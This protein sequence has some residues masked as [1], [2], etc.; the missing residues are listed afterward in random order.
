MR[1]NAANTRRRT[2]ARL[3]L[4][5]FV[6]AV[7]TLGVS[8]AVPA[9]PADAQ[10]GVSAFGHAASAA[11]Q[12]AAASRTPPRKGEFNLPVAIVMWSLMGMGG[13]AY[14]VMWVQAAARHYD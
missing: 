5:L 9:A 10:T 13:I 12:D 8:V 14:L 4:A 2:P 6:S 7:S 3:L 11:D 1:F